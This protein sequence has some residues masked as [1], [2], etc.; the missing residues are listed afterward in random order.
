MRLLY[1]IIPLLFFTCDEEAIE[2]CT[3]SGSC[4]FLA[5]ANTD[6]GSCEYFDECNVCGGDGL[7][8]GFD[9]SGNC[10]ADGGYD[11]NNVCGGTAVIDECGVCEGNNL[12]CADCNGDVNG[13]ALELCDFCISFDE[14]LPDFESMY[15]SSSLLNM[16]NNYNPDFSNTR[17]IELFEAESSYIFFEAQNSDC[18]ILF[19]SPH[20][21]QTYRYND[22]NG[23]ECDL[24]EIHG[25]EFRTGVLAKILN[26][27]SGCPAITKKY[28]SDDPNHHHVIPECTLT[29]VFE[30]KIGERLPYK[31]KIYN[32]IGQSN[33]INLVIDLHGKNSFS[34]Y[35]DIDLGTCYD[36]TLKSAVGEC[37][38]TIINYI[39]LKRNITVS[40]NS[41]FASCESETVTRFVSDYI[42]DVVDAIQF[43]IENEYR[44]CSNN[45]FSQLVYSFLEI[46]YIA[47]HL[48][49]SN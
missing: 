40:E 23:T 30:N 22:L 6:D 35:E 11:C 24:E 29:D 37:M 44:S 34:R 36:N 1:L 18:R 46:I 4:N 15:P 14:I 21:Q 3:D 45:R 38:P 20:S 2:G 49:S 33:F 41:E 13:S 12:S 47:N 26:E 48:Y 17:D 43:E 7:E 27:L 32:Y 5:D 28:L 31:E 16:C 9:C 42:E 10:I 8:E 19:S 39:M 25:R